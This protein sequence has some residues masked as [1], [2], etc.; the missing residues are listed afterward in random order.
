M[1][2]VP[3]VMGALGK[4]PWRLVAVAVVMAALAFAG[5][6]VTTWRE[7]FVRLP[8]VQ[9]KLDAEV[10]CEPATACQ[11]R[12]AALAEL[13]REEAAIAAQ[14]ALQTAQEREAKARADAAAWRAKYRAAVQEDPVCA[15]WSRQPVRCPL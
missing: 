8:D 7:A 12:A 9:A 15:D 14:A 13:A 5:W 3:L 6:R 10:A 2:P 11:E 4:V 1:I